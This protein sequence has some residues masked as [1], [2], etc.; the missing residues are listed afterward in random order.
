MPPLRLPKRGRA[1]ESVP[2]SFA[3]P[4]IN[5]V[6]NHSDERAREFAI[7]VRDNLIDAT[8]KDTGWAAI[9]WEVSVPGQETPASEIEGSVSLEAIER[10]Y[11]AATLPTGVPAYRV[12]NDI[13]Y[14][15]RLNSGS[16]TQ[17]PAG[18]VQATLIRTA[19]QHGI[20]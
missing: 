10:A 6:V 12:V 16:S 8:P 11:E 1:R 18:F 5:D 13:P 2:R 4:I 3:T 9:N 20:D 19:A 7:A 15:K 17:A 14:I